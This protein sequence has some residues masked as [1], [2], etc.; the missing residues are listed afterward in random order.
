MGPGQGERTG[1]TS[2]VAVSTLP[3]RLLI[4]GGDPTE[5][6]A[7]ARD[8]F[9]DFRSLTVTVGGAHL[10]AR[11]PPASNRLRGR[12]FRMKP[13][14]YERVMLKRLRS[15]TDTIRAAAFAVVALAARMIGPAAAAEGGTSN[16]PARSPNRRHPG[17][18]EG[19]RAAGFPPSGPGFPARRRRPT[20]PDRDPP[21]V[22]R[23]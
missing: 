19:R 3:E 8:T 21:R 13:R 23:Q 5:F 17:C 2:E 1:A 4:I 20:G 14:V 16:L 11:Q 7:L 10:Y 9:Y 15:I 12:T 6:Q 22:D 18:R